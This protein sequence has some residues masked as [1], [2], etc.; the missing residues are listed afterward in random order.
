MNRYHRDPAV[1]HVGCL[2]PRAYFIPFPPGEAFSAERSD[3]PF[4]TSLCGEWAFAW[5][6]DA[7]ALDW[8]APGFPADLRCEDTIAVPGCWQL[9]LG[10]GYDPPNYINQD[11]PYPVDPPHLPDSIPGGLYRKTLRLFP[12]SARR[13]TLTFEGVSSCFYLWVNGRFIGYSEVS[14]CVSEFDVT[15]ALKNGENVF[16]VFVLKHCT[17]SYLED[18]DFFRLSGIFREVY[19][20]SR[21][22]AYIKD[23]ELR[24]QT[25]PDFGTARILIA[26]ETE[27]APILLCTLRA[28]DG[29]T[30]W[31][32]S[33]RNA[34]TAELNA[35]VLWS[36]ET[37]ALYELTLETDGEAVRFSVG[38]RDVRIENGALLF[39]GQTIKLRG[40]NR[41]DTAPETGYTV[42]QDEMLRD[43]YLMKRANV[44]C[45]RTSH[46]PNDPRFAGLC[47]ELGFYVINEA[48]LESHGMGYNYGDWDWRYWAFLCD[49]PDWKAACVDRAARLYERDKNHPCVLMWSLGNESGCGENHREMA[50]Y[51][52]SRAP[53]ALIHYENAHLEYA[54]RIGRDFSD[55]SDVES[56]MYAPLDYLHGYL[57]APEH[58]KP[59]FYCEYVSANT[60]GDIPLHWA[61]FEAYANYAGG[62]VWEFSDHAVNVGSP[63]APR[64]RYGGDF[65]D[66]PNDGICCLDG[67]V[68]PDRRPRPG[69]YDMKDAYKPFSVSYE[70]GTLTVKNKYVFRSLNGCRLHWVFQRDGETITAGDTDP[71]EIPPR[72]TQTFDLCEPEVKTGFLT[73]IVRLILSAG[74]AWAE[75]GFEVG[76]A[77]FI[78]RDAPVPLPEPRSDR[79]AIRYEE[80]REHITIRALS[81]TA[82]INKRM[83]T[84]VSLRAERELLSEPADFSIFKAYLPFDSSAKSWERARYDRAKKKTYSV[85][86]VSADETSVC[87]RVE[88]SFAAAAMPPALRGTANY[89]FFADGRIRLDARVNVTEN[90]PA[91][92]RFGL[93]LPLTPDFEKMEY[94]GYGPVEAYPDRY[95]S[96][97][98]EAHRT[99]VTENFVHYIRPTENGAHYRTKRA[100]I[101]GSDGVVLHFADRSERGFTFNAKHYTDRQLHAA[102]HDDEL[103]PT[104]QT[105]VRLD[106]KTHAENPAHAEREPERLF[107]DKSFGFSWE[108]LVETP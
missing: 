103:V 77:Q 36:A 100:L 64:Y 48:D 32:A 22:A 39:N 37:P 91:L 38:I 4:F 83:G 90:A 27:G 97:T 2:A 9:C 94:L 42:R 66:N 52:R 47:D 16:E 33:G 31:E 24:T 63:E 79:T 69:Y 12:S 20:L 76:H 8:D 73:L 67:L 56:R 7:E 40:V 14:H 6:P 104:E 11:Y 53:G 3:S 19:L 80:D 34:F 85:T 65:G 70:N 41:H 13:Y 46:Y 55:I 57:N 51:I 15:E 60:T 105:I 82:V 50:R 78:L 87:V 101:R 29:E 58:T 93:M 92:P 99:T 44:N 61:G 98:L 74:T 88:F 35:P 17:G 1:Q 28:P 62:C 30:V 84:I 26:A 95:R 102:A 21:P 18:Q 5:F 49:S 106:Y 108:I 72:G 68:F 43:L 107:T 25:A 89:T 71:L 96:Q 10:R 81:Y 86:A 45:I 54:A 23:V 59:F 75:P